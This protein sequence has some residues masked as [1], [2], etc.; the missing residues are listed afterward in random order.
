MAGGITIR[1]DGFAEAAFSLQPAWHGLGTV[2]DHMMSSKEAFT[3]AGL[4]WTVE[5]R[6]AAVCNPLVA[7]GEWHLQSF[8]PAKG[9]RFNI[10]SD[11]KKILGCVTDHYKV[12]QNCEAFQ[13]LDALIENNEMLYESAFSLYGGRK[14]VVLAKMPGYEQVADGDPILPYILMSLQHDGT[15]AIK[16]GPCAV[17]VVCANTYTVALGEGRIKEMSIRHSGDIQHKLS[18]ARDILQISKEGFNQY[19][20]TG[21]KL[22]QYRMSLQMWDEYLNIMCPPLD[23]RDP[24]Y[25]ERRAEKLDETRSLI[26]EAFHNDRQNFGSISSTAWSAYNAVSEH[27][28]HLPRRGASVLSKSEARFNVCLYGI[29]RDM[30]ERAFQLACRF[31]GI[32]TSV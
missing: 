9:Y 20:G 21:Q 30:K 18:Q 6:D 1:A 25:T 29:G 32:S 24:D 23:P 12:V 16:F 10:R 15:G 27:I 11:S 4:D 26:E 22:A 7:D 13:F 2:F 19:V 31:A 8:S 17:R 28:D 3:A 5:Q 14:V